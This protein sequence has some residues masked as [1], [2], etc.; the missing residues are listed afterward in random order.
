MGHRAQVLGFWEAGNSKL[1]EEN[2][3]GS[4]AEAVSPETNMQE[5]IMGE[6]DGDEEMGDKEE[7]LCKPCSSE[8]RE[9]QGIILPELPSEQEVRLHG[10][11]GHVP[12]RSWCIHCVRGCAVDKQ[13]KRS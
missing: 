9:V 10:L 1:K 5:E 13:H 12:Y 8:D 2:D 4:R 3:Q 11:R 6:S 7:E